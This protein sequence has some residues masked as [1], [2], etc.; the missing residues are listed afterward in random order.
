MSRALRPSD[1]VFGA[2]DCMS[3]IVQGRSGSLTL[4]QI[5][6]PKLYLSAF[7]RYRAVNLQPTIPL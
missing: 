7:S 5:E 6:S 1:Y 3:L 4:A 2:G